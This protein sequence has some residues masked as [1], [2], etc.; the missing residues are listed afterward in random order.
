V[1]CGCSPQTPVPIGDVF[2]PA[3]AVAGDVV[4]FANTTGKLIADSGIP[5]AVLV[6]NPA[7]STSGHLASFGDASGNLIGD[8]GASVGELLAMRPDIFGS[9]SDGNLT[10]AAGTTTLTRDTYY[11]TVTLTG[12]AKIVTAGFKLFILHW[13]ASN[14]PAAA[15][16][17]SGNQGGDAIIG[18]SAGNTGGPALPA[19]T[20]AGSLVGQNGGD[21]VSTGNG[22]AGGNAATTPLGCGGTGGAGG[23]GG[24]G[25]NGAGGVAG[26]GGPITTRPQL[27][28]ARQEL[29]IMTASTTIT[30]VS[31]GGPGGGGGGGGGSGTGNSGGP[32]GG[33]GSGGGA[34]FLR[35]KKLTV[36]ASTTAG[37]C[38][39]IGGR[40]GNGARSDLAG[41][42]GGG[43]GGGG[44]GGGFIHAVVGQVVGPAVANFFDAS[45]GNG[46]NG[47][48]GNGTG[49]SGTAGGGGQGGEVVLINLAANTATVSTRGNA[50][51][52]TG[53]T[54]RLGV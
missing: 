39:A 16:D 33:S 4:V 17:R 38:A 29:A 41:N 32:A 5:A 12:T 19:A 36:S 18:S 53:G 11:N 21:P 3:T 52:Q 23:T 34:L 35:V 25:G 45:G 20:V 8:A 51:G 49:T 1:S 9:G 37:A 46:G 40:G 26:T 54:A 31:G 50:V 14:A 43:S 48:T 30:Q 2:G 10:A 47:A 42:V 13:D 28:D 6:V 22:Q 15:I 27:Y 44:A 24:T 7:P